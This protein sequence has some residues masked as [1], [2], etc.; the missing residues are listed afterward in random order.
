MPKRDADDSGERAEHTESLPSLA[1]GRTASCGDHVRRDGVVLAY[2]S[3][4]SRSNRARWAGG[5]SEAIVVLFDN[6]PNPTRL[7]RV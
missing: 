6:S 3:Q 1:A 5:F 4:P 2:R 7:V